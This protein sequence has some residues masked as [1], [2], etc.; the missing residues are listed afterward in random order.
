[1]PGCPPRTCR[2]SP[3]E[4]S[5]ECKV[6]VLQQ[7]RRKRQ[8]QAQ[9]SQP[10]KAAGEHVHVRGKCCYESCNDWQSCYWWAWAFSKN[11]QPV[12]SWQ[13]CACIAFIFN[14]NQSIDWQPNQTKPKCKIDQDAKN[15]VMLGVP[16]WKER[17]LSKIRR[18][19]RITWKNDYSLDYI[20]S[21]VC[22]VFTIVKREI[23]W[24]FNYIYI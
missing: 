3:T 15:I 22:V 6:M 2:V 10:K 11:W 8:F 19:C 23:K 24:W 13:C 21:F 16:L 5:T 1:M 7:R 9:A 14:Y 18:I 12:K 17:I 4:P 20:N